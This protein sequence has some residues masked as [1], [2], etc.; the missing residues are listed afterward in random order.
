MD[1]LT[2]VILCAFAALIIVIVYLAELA[3]REDRRWEDLDD[4]DGAHEVKF[5][6]KHTG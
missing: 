4:E 5:D 3:R 2:V 6:G 1:A